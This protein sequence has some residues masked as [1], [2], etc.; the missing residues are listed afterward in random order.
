MENN[1]LEELKKLD[2]ALLQ[3]EVDPDVVTDFRSGEAEQYLVWEVVR[4]RW[5]AE[6]Q[7]RDQVTVAQ[8]RIRDQHPVVNLRVHGSPDEQVI[9]NMIAVMNLA[10]RNEAP[11]AIPKKKGRPKVAQQGPK[12]RFVTL[13][14]HRV[15]LEPV[16]AGLYQAR[17]QR[18]GY[19]ALIQIDREE[20]QILC[21]IERSAETLDQWT[22][23]PD[24]RAG[25]V[26]WAQVQDQAGELSDRVSGLITDDIEWARARAE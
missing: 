21:V 7:V 22:V 6:L 1:R 8:L 23:S 11:A 25:S 2:V 3:I 9:Q 14:G 15:G 12:K 20:P 13:L 5:V 18:L 26:F 17:A 10:Y 24:A 4:G 16:G 19:K